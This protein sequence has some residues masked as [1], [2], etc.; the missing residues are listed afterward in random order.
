MPRAAPPQAAP[1]KPQP[2]KPQRPRAKQRLHRRKPLRLRKALHRRKLRLRPR[3]SPRV[4]QAEIKLLKVDRH[5]TQPIPTKPLLHR[6]TRLQTRQVQPTIP[7]QIHRLARNR[8]RSL[9][10]GNND[11]IHP[12]YAGSLQIKNDLRTSGHSRPSPAKP[13]SAHFLPTWRMMLC[14]FTTL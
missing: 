10:T 7:A 13:I 12:P 3:P 11:C 9:Q 5:R 4:R 2:L 6:L 8:N 1:L 14:R